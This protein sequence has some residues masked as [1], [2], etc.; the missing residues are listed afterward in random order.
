VGHYSAATVLGTRWLTEDF[1]DGTLVLVAKGV[2][3]VEDLATHA[4]VTVRAGHSAFTPAAA[5]ARR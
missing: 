5:A 1:C 2:V 4:T 3:V